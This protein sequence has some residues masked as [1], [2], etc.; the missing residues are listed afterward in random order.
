MKRLLGEAARYGAASAIALLVDIGL[1]AFLVQRLSWGYLEAGCASF[2]AGL[3]VAYTLSV[4]MVFRHRRVSD[5]RLEFLSFAAIGALGLLVNTAVMWSA[6]N[7]AGAGYLGAKC[8]AA[9]ITFAC[10]FGLRRAMLFSG[11]LAD[12]KLARS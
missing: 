8:A 6:V 3:A 10:N 1:L 7:L 4:K 11:C 9:G 12:G 2:T 5:R